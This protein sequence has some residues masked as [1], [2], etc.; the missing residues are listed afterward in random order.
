MGMTVL[1]MNITT[2]TPL[3]MGYSNL[4]T[5]PEKVPDAHN[6]Y[7]CDLSWA[8]DLG[9]LLSA[10]YIDDRESSVFGFL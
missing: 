10:Q 5:I 2:G 7:H 6:R 3:F 1:Q 8:G 9:W 4:L